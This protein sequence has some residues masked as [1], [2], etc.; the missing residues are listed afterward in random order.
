MTQDFDRIIA[1]EFAWI[2][3]NELTFIIRGN[4]LTGK[5]GRTSS[6]ESIQVQISIP[7][8]YPIVRPNIRVLTKITH[9]NIDPDGTLNLQISDEWTPEYRLKDVISS[10]RRLFVRS[11]G[12]IVDKTPVI[13]SE[14]SHLENQIQD[15]QKEIADYNKKITE[16]KT[17]QLSTVGGTS[18]GIASFKINQRMDAECQLNAMNDLLEL[19]KMKFEEAELD[20]INFFR[21][22][23]KYIRER[24]IIVRQLNS[25]EGIDYELPKT[26]TKEPIRN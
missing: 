26:K 18:V 4:I 6:G 2:T 11:K 24:Y 25:L 5:V 7:E 15:L 17:Q 1:Q 19:L 8:F 3:K 13:R 20:Q 23:K 9:P 21:L 22:Y 12:S 14:T 16:V 10:I